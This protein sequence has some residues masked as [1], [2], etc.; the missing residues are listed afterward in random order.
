MSRGGNPDAVWYNSAMRRAIRAAMTSVLTAGVALG[1]YAT[2][3]HVPSGDRGDVGGG[4]RVAVEQI[5]RRDDGSGRIYWAA[6]PL[7]PAR[8]DLFITPPEP[9]LPGGAT[10]RLRRT[11]DLA[12]T[13]HLIVAVNASMFAGGSRP[14]RREGEPARQVETTVADGTVVSLWEHTYML[15]FTP[16]LNAEPVEHKPPPTEQMKGWRWGIGAQS[17]QLFGGQRAWW[18]KGE[19]TRRT[20][21]GLSADRRTLYLAVFDHA[22][23]ARS[24]E[25]LAARGAAWVFNLDGSESSAF[26]VNGVALAGDWR[27]VANHFGAALK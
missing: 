2:V 8:V 13:E 11:T 6:I 10:H 12:R 25:E 14:V 24:A 17:W 27:P 1:A 23:H 22:D 16:A 26:V 5:D 19:V 15:G 9:G 18:G 4:V 3:A 21:V 20:T 7:D